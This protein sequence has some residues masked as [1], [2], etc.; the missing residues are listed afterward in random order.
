MEIA[1]DSFRL[2]VFD[3][4]GTLYDQKRLRL[5]MA[6]QLGL[7]CAHTLNLRTAKVLKRYRHRREQ[8]ADAETTNFER[9]LE[10]ELVAIYGGG[11]GQLR[12]LIADWMEVRPL[13]YLAAARR[14]GV[15]E[16]FNRLRSAGKAIGILSDY[17]ARAKIAALGLDADFVV[18]A[19]DGDV[20]VM[21]PNPAGLQH[22]MAL[23]DTP[24]AD[25]VMIGDRTERDG[26]AGRRA[27]VRTLIVGGE[28]SEHWVGFRDFRELWLMQGIVS[29]AG[30]A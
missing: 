9:V 21:K 3:L 27:G 22:V 8:L 20:N 6:A 26:E 10:A 17:P 30:V 12:D 14:P 7:H 28:T 11:G 18:S 15:P 23:A 16:L 29:P 19:T 13:P 4:D 2:A 1:W 24:P 25:A 5:I